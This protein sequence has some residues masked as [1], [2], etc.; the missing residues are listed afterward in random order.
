MEPLSS[1]NITNEFLYINQS[2]WI[3]N[4]SNIVFQTGSVG[5]GTAAPR[6]NLDVYGSINALSANFGTVYTGSTSFS[7]LNVAGN[8]NIVGNLTVSN[9]I[10]TGNYVNVVSNTQFSNAVTINNAGTSTALKVH[11]LE[12]VPVHTN[13]VAEFWDYQT[14]ALLINGDGN[15]GIHTTVIN[16]HAFA[17]AGSSNLEYIKTINVYSSNAVSA[18]NLYGNVV[19]SNT[20]SASTIYGTLAGANTVTGSTLYGTLAG[21]NTVSSSGLYGPVVGSNTV[22]ASTIYGTLAGANTITGSSVS[23]TTLYGQLAGA[24]TIAGSSMTLT[25]ALNPAYGGTGLSSYTVG[26]IIYA[27]GTTA[28]SSLAD[29]ATGSALISGGVGVAPSWGKVGLTTHVSGTLPVANGGTN[30]TSYTVGDIIYASGTTALS[31]L[32]DVATGSALISGGVGVAPSWG[33]VGLTTHVSGTLPVA[34]GGTNLTTYTSG[35]LVYASGTGTLASSG[36]YTAGQ[37]LYGGGTGSAPASTSTLFW[38]SGNSRLGVNSS[39]PGYTLDVS[40]TGRFNADTLTI[41]RVSCTTNFNVNGQITVNSIAACAWI[42]LTTPVYTEFSWTG[43]Q[44]FAVSLNTAVPTTARAILCDVFVTASSNDHQNIC[45]SRSAAEYARN[46]VDTRGTQPSTYF[47]ANP[48]STNHTV[49]LTYNGEAD[50]F[51][52]NYGIWYS[53]QYVPCASRQIYFGNYGN[54]GSNGWVYIVIRA[55]TL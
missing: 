22:A 48:P 8:S 52:Q 16:P 29:V 42:E 10:V 33:K 28:L 40:G 5:I 1:E 43:S 32:A 13:N 2:Q 31:S 21:A 49:R 23:A 11:Q 19:G 38:D 54:S 35:G 37:V 44:S 6:A 36:A 18:S 34:N 26:D 25:T 20:V 41:P 24:N 15:V 46:W 12:A 4:G 3:S 17:V 9:L 55:Y 53:S 47:G 50:G 7:T 30:I 51:T 27:S 45:L 39:T 14:L